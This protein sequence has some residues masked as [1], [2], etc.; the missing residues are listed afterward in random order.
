MWNKKAAENQK[1][2]KPP[3]LLSSLSSSTTT[4]TKHNHPNSRNIKREP[5][6]NTLTNT[7]QSKSSSNRQ[8]QNT[9]EPSDV[10]A[11]GSYMERRIGNSNS[12][13]RDVEAISNYQPPLGLKTPPITTR[14]T[15]IRHRAKMYAIHETIRYI[16]EQVSDRRMQRLFVNGNTGRADE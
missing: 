16:K 14:G 7:R 6:T 9:D 10:W 15:W 8:Q 2:D 11:D 13:E 5:N 4:A 1:G 12:C 3:H